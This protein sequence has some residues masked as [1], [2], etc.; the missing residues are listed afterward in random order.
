[1]IKTSIFIMPR[2]ST[3]WVGAEAL[4]ITVAGW[5][6][7]AKRK[8]GSTWVITSDRIVQPEEVIHYPRININSFS[9]KGKSL[10]WIPQFIKTVIKDIRLWQR[11]LNW[12][13]VTQ[14]PWAT[15]KVAFVWQQH[16]LFSGP[17]RKLATKL[18]VPLITYVHA[19]VVWEAAKWGVKRYLWGYFLERFIEARAL[20]KS[21]I[22]ACVSKD[23]ADKLVQMGIEEKKILISPMAVDPFLFDQQINTELRKELGLNDKIVIG[24]TGSFRSFHGLDLLVKAF[25]RVNMREPKSRL[26]LI[27]DGFERNS[28]E[29]LVKELQLSDAVIFTGKLPFAKIPSYVAAFD[30]AVVSARSSEG[31]HYSPLKLREYLMAGKPVL[32]PFA[33]DIPQRFMDNFHLKLYKVGN[34]EELTTKLN[35]LIYNPA[36]STLL[37]QQGKK[38]ALETGTWDSELTKLIK[39]LFNELH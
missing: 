29:D 39:K 24:W 16:D 35:E 34:V 12:S 32:A 11:S 17:G 36:E 27:G 8:F 25:Q 15:E 28:L 18:N 6:A 26:L 13:I 2:A 14:Q 1:M 5:S 23:V 7:A 31:F 21:D 20:K 37:G 9:S 4:W 22:V 38:Y 3:S 10:K 19:P 30:I 33:G